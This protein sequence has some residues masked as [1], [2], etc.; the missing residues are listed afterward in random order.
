[1]CL[2]EYLAMV[3]NQEVVVLTGSNSPKPLEIYM[4]VYECDLLSHF[5]SMCVL[6]WLGL[7]VHSERAEI[8]SAMVFEN[9]NQV[10]LTPTL[11]PRVQWHQG[12]IR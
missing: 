5:S 4:N 3:Y 1:M 6:S 2:L 8:T 12:R 10:L 7:I 11:N 9:S